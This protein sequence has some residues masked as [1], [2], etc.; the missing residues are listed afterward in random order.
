[1]RCELALIAA[2][3]LTACPGTI[4]DPEA[5]QVDCL[6]YV[7]HYLAQ[8]CGASCHSA[9]SHEADLDLET[10]PVGPRLAGIPG[11]QD[12]CDTYSLLDPATPADSL[13]YLKV[14]SDQPPCGDRMPLL[15]HTL[16]DPQLDCVL[17]WIAAQPVE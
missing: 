14:A 9:S 7:D 17:E 11:S 4:D 1:M 10:L 16:T 6:T 5:F 15:G 3:A 8:T 2:V 13:L 12:G